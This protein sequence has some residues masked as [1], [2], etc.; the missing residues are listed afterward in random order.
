MLIS[1]QARLSV[2]GKWSKEEG[3]QL[4][5]LVAEKGPRWAEIS[6]SLGRLPEGCRDKWR[7]LKLGDAKQNGRWSEDET[8]SLRSL[9]NDYMN[10]KQVCMRLSSC[11][12]SLQM[13]KIKD[14]VHGANIG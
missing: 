4:R 3:E 1:H 10:K 8:E 7:E 14:M 9:V 2:Q 6:R 12:F 13:G 11:M 5:Q